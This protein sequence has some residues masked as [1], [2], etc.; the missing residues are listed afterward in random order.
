MDQ[1]RKA[2]ALEA[3]MRAIDCGGPL[4]PQFEITLEEIRNR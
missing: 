4:Q 3:V 1:D 2:E